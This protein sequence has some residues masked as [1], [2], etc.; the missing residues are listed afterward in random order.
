M[1]GSRHSVFSDPFSYQAAI[2][3]ADVEMSVRAAGAFRAELTRVDLTH[4]WMQRGYEKLARV[5][6]AA[7]A[8]NRAIIYFHSSPNQASI[9]HSGMEVNTDEIVV[10][11]RAAVH[12]HWTSA[13][14]H[15]GSMSLSHAALARMSYAITGRELTTPTATRKVRPKPADFLRLRSLHDTVGHFAKATPDAFTNGEAV[16]S[17]EASLIHAMINCLTDC[18]Q[19]EMTS[20]CRSH[21]AIVSRLEGFLIA[22]PDRPL[23]LAEL[24]AATGATER[25]LRVSCNEHLGMGPIHY[26]WLRRMHL[27]RRAL[28]RSDPEVASVTDIAMKHGFW[29]LGRFSVAY[30]RLF[31]ETPSATLRRPAME[32]RTLGG[33]PLSLP[34]SEIA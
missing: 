7:N 2:R 12:H 1:L 34:D 9:H 20:G 10:Y 27:V 11:A 18:E 28:L 31:G 8:S 15:W 26:L 25:T 19:I 5:S 16:R 4:L 13:P 33:S 21:L 24:C 22:N 14:L 29:Q 23:Y 30:R 3:A 6:H 17:I 32:D